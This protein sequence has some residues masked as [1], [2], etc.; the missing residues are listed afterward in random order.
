LASQRPLAT[1]ASLPCTVE[2]SNTLLHMANPHNYH[3]GNVRSVTA[4]CALDAPH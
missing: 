4:S 3:D 1:A 2:V